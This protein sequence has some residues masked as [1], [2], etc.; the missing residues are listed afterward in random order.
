ME[1]QIAGAQQRAR[2]V[3][4]ALYSTVHVWPVSNSKPA[5][6]SELCILLLRIS[7]S[8]KGSILHKSIHTSTSMNRRA[9]EK[10]W[11]WVGR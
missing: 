3:S 10:N 6:D 1:H 2:A 11:L 7:S 5:G 9:K 4:S 8:L